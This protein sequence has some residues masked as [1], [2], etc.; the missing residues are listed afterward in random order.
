MTLN[1]QPD[2][3]S[4]QSHQVRAALTYFVVKAGHPADEPFKSTGGAAEY[5]LKRTIPIVADKS[6]AKLQVSQQLDRERKQKTYFS[7]CC[8]LTL[9]Q[10]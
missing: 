1:F 2:A 6:T 4:L 5:P 7:A 9:A 10:T 3:I 8:T